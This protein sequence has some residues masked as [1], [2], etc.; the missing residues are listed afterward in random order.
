MKNPFRKKKSINAKVL[1]NVIM[2]SKDIADTIKYLRRK[3]YGR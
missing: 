1:K 3:Y 2:N